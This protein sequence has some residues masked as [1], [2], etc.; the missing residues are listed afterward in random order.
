MESTP[1][2]VRRS[3]LTQLFQRAYSFKKEWSSRVPPLVY[4]EEYNIRV[5][6]LEKM[7]PMDSCKFGKIVSLLE[8]SGLCR[9]S[10]LPSPAPITDD[11]LL[12]VHTDAYVRRVQNDKTYISQILELPFAFLVPKSIIKRCL[13]QPM[14]FHT[15]GTI[16]AMALA[17]ERG[18]A[19]NIGPHSLHPKSM[20]D[21]VWH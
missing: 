20:G 7:H 12:E 9:R 17:M 19:I 18:W 1:A 15:G 14:R 21:T 8:A 4:R 11:D 13:I 6:G 10:D 2:F 5:Y 3:D 16:L